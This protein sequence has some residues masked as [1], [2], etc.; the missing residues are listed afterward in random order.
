MEHHDMGK[1]LEMMDEDMS[2]VDDLDM[3]M[4]M[5][6]NQMDHMD[7]M[8][9]SERIFLGRNLF[10]DLKYF[11]FRNDLFI[12][13]RIW[14]GIWPA[15]NFKTSNWSRLCGFDFDVPRE[16]IYGSYEKWVALK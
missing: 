14:S 6:M 7:N 12:I 8:D 9:H 5:D 4:K 1:D 10:V 16:I 11:F 13:P 2:I 3:K 15:V